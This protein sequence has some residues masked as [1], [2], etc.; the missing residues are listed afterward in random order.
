M[1]YK[2]SDYLHYVDSEKYRL[3]SLSNS[4]LTLPAAKEPLD[5]ELFSELHGFSSILANDS[6][7]F[8]IGGIIG[9]IISDNVFQITPSL[10]KIK[11]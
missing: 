1:S 3:Y 6:N 4:C 5:P 2:R 9:N 10:Q 11:N 8:I 7:L